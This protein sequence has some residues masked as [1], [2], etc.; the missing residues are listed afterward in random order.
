MTA[1]PRTAERRIT[2]FMEDPDAPRP[3]NPIH[4]TAGG[5][6]YG[7]RAALVGGVA[8]YCW[9]APANIEAL[10]ES[11]LDRAGVRSPSGGRPTHHGQSSPR[12]WSARR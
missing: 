11:W 5:R 7:Y 4:P 6:E 1:G 10:G 2:A 12:R 3:E 9:A 8:V